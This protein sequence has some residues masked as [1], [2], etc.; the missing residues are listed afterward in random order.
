MLQP[1]LD[2]NEVTAF[3]ERWAGGAVAGV[4]QFSNGQVSSVFS[5]DVVGDFREV[6]KEADP[7]SKDGMYVVR[8]VSGEHSEGLK[9]YRFIAPRATA[10]GVPV[11]RV[12][13]HGETPMMVA[14]LIDEERVNHGD[15]AFLLGFVICDRMT[16]EHMG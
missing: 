12:V 8:F 10:A 13:A 6:L 1:V 3:L 4:S 9:K 2:I 7:E 14:N 16:G 15:G 5:F 11:P